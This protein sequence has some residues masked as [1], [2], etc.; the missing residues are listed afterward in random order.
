MR[1]VA[2]SPR[3]EQLSEFNFFVSKSIFRNVYIND[4]N[5]EPF[6]DSFLATKVITKFLDSGTLHRN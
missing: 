4:H 2:V 5:L 6:V 1:A 3:Y